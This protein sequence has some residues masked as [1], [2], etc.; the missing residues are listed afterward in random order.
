MAVSRRNFTLPGKTDEEAQAWLE[1]RL[2]EVEEEIASGK[3]TDQW[4]AGDSSAHK[5]ID[6]NLDAVTRRQMILNDLG[7]LDPTTY[8]PRDNAAIKRTVS[9]YL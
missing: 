5:M 2:K 1:E 8:P 3:V 4:S 9:R 7:I 6:R